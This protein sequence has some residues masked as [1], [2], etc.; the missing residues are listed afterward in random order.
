MRSLAL[1]AVAAASLVVCSTAGAETT[2]ATSLTI[3]FRATETAAPVVRTLRCGPAGGTL[4]NAARACARLAALSKP[5]APVPRDAICTEIYGGPQTARV[6]GTYRDRRIWT[7]F[8][9]RNGCEIERWNRHAFL[10]PTTG[11]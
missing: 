4:R 2:P 5:F 7:I 6:T 11:S 9:R 8:R 3:V 1:P 10:F